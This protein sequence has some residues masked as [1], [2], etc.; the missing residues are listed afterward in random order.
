[1]EIIYTDDASMKLGNGVRRR[2]FNCGATE[3]T[4]WRRSTISYGKL[5]CNRCGLYERTHFMA[6]PKNFPRRR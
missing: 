6:R 5:L 4:T 3:T 2:C 1:Y